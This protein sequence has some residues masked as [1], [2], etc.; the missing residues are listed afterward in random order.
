MVTKRVWSNVKFIPDNNDL[1]K[2]IKKIFRL[3]NLNEVKD[4]DGNIVS[5]NNK[6][7]PV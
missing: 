2:L 5:V 3:M 6:L 7:T 4:E 1:T